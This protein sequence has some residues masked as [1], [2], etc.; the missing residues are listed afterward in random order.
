MMKELVKIVPK[1][2]EFLK[3]NNAVIKPQ[4]K[5]LAETLPTESDISK[6]NQ[7]NLLKLTQSVSELKLPMASIINWMIAASQVVNS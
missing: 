1:L 5:K 7:D 3:Y 6:Q 4:I 2:K